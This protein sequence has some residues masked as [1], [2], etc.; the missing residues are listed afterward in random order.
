MIDSVSVV[1]KK[2]ILV[3]IALF[4]LSACV[5]N[6]VYNVDSRVF[7]TNQNLP[8]ASVG[9][10]IKLIGADRGWTF[11]DVTSGHMIGR[12]GTVKHNARADI[13]YTNTTFS[14]QYLDS[15]NLKASNGIIHHRYN[16]WIQFLEQ[17]LVTKLGLAAQ[18]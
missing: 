15:H 7:S 6:P 3:L 14:I 4:V 1:S 9:E 16:R 11:T 18:S 12:V 17:D 13:R 2:V 10:K 8:I 5:S